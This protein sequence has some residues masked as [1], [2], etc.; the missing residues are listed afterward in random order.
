MSSPELTALYQRH[1]LQSP[2]TLL[3][4]ALA[5]QAWSASMGLAQQWPERLSPAVTLAALA[6]HLPFSGRLRSPVDTLFRIPAPGADQPPVL[7]AWLL[8]LVRAGADPDRI[9]EGSW[10]KSDTWTGSVHALAVLSE[11][12]ETLAH[13]ATLSPVASWSERPVVWQGRTTTLL[14]LACATERWAVARFL[15]DQGFPPHAPDATEAQPWEAVDIQAPVTSNQ[16]LFDKL[17]LWPHTEAELAAGWGRLQALPGSKRAMAHGTAWRTRM[18][19]CG[20]RTDTFALTV[21]IERL[22]HL[23]THPNQTSL[24]EMKDLAHLW[25][26]S[27][28]AARER[29]LPIRNALLRGQWS[30]AGA[31]AWLGATLAGK[32]VRRLPEGKGAQGPDR[33]GALQELDIFGTVLPA[34]SAQELD[35]PI[36]ERRL[37]TGDTITLT[38]RGLWN[39][40][41]LRAEDALPRHEASFDYADRPPRFCGNTGPGGQLGRDGLSGHHWALRFVRTGTMVIALRHHVDGPHLF[42]LLVTLSPSGVGPSLL[43]QA[44]ALPPAAKPWSP[45]ELA[46]LPS[47]W[48]LLTQANLTGSARPAMPTALKGLEGE[49]LVDVTQRWGWPRPRT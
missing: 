10:E 42:K 22:L 43:F 36:T 39:M 20:V 35:R 23:G 3:D 26:T 46:K 1:A 34:L 11:S 15:V 8:A 47:P 28:P 25:S 18:A 4:D 6:R 49:R 27:S 14:H 17:G 31:M 29:P 13:L 16:F 7:D 48:A 41:C 40:G 33:F 38:A 21:A 2:E 44:L 19:C 45:K 30:L 24:P 12:L 5:H 37:V 9:L 32:V